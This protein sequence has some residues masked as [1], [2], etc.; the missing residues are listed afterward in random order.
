MKQKQGAVEAEIAEEKKVD[1]EL[2][3]K[4]LVQP[5]S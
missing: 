4:T 5:F 2:K 1:R 3:W